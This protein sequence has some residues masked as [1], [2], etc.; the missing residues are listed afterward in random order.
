MKV[1]SVKED[2]RKVRVPGSPPDIDSD[3]EALRRD[4]VK[5]YLEDKYGK[6]RV[7][8]IGTYTTLKTKQ[9]IRD[10]C[11]IHGITQ[12]EMNYI[13]KLIEVTSEEVN[14]AVRSRMDTFLKG[15]LSSVPLREFWKKHPDLIEDLE[16][17]LNSPKSPSVH[18]CGMIILPDEMALET[19][20]PLRLAEK[21]GEK[22]LV[23]EWEGMDL[24]YVG[25]LKEDILGINQ[26]D[27]FRNILNLIKQNT[28]EE[29]DIYSVPLDV[30][31]VYTMFQ[32]GENGDVFHIGS[33]SLTEY[34]KLVKPTQFED[35]AAILSLYRPGP[36]ESQ[37]HMK[38]IGLKE[39]REKPVYFPYL[40]QTTKETFG[41][42]VYQ[43][44]TIEAC[45][46]IAD[47]TL[48]EAD[49]VRRALGKMDV[50]YLKPFK[51][52]FIE[53]A[54][55]KQYTSPQAEELW[56]TLERMAA[57]Q[58]N[59]SHAVA[60]AMTGYICQYLK[61]KYPLEYW[62][63]ALQFAVKPEKV[64][65]Y[66]AEINNSSSGIKVLPPDVNVAQVG[67]KTDYNTKE[68]FW[69]LDS[70]KHCGGVAVSEIIREREEN[71]PF[72]SLEE[73]YSRV[74]KNKVNKRVIENLI[75]GGAFDKIEGITYPSQRRLLMEKLEGLVKFETKVTD[76]P[77]TCEDWWWYLKQK[78][79]LN[80][81]TIDLEPFCEIPFIFH[82]ITEILEMYIEKK[83]RSSTGG[84]VTQVIE[85]NS[86]KGTF[87]EV[88]IEDN[89]Q[90][91][92]V[93]VW[94][95][96]WDG[97]RDEIMNSKGKILFVNGDVMYDKFR[98]TLVLQTLDQSQIQI[99]G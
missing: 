15:A 85:K 66:I 35:L 27:K 84:V 73:F 48:G 37:T 1:V 62:T 9:G 30:P 49:E 86:V 31:E 57:Y 26:L 5:R 36:I 38:Y 42:F 29:V 14:R 93:V 75:Y 50:N 65:E 51:I 4:E 33:K 18:P 68:I 39:G 91:L 53:K 78:Q 58:F 3:F 69:S 6:N 70:I 99:I 74:P 83:L 40:E 80:L 63:T 25:Y 92:C 43:E 81:G 8:S 55:E 95:R 89:Y 12:G 59:K 64:I 90:T 16:L 28:G 56:T 88:F 34:T 13:S 97:F 32:K 11:K 24:E 77:E 2:V 79:V 76:N 19:S 52:R 87:G 7:C 17:L 44:Q 47:L 96:V 60:Y 67:F 45:R 46:I 21:D 71:G 20:L 72:Y 22:I 94:S 82:S 41:L 23:S 61:W 10:L 98:K 54:L